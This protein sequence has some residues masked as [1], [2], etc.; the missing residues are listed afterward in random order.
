M[1]HH[2][3]SPSSD[4]RTYQQQNASAGSTNHIA[5]VCQLK[6]QLFQLSPPIDLG[7]WTS[8]DVHTSI[9]CTRNTHVADNCII[10]LYI[11]TGNLPPAVI[12]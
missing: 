5:G 7:A 1:V 9:C 2:G 10:Q 11:K 6:I 12:L 4:V 3:S 8:F